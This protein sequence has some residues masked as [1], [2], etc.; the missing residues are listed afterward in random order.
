MN[1]WLKFKRLT[2]PGAKTLVTVT[3]IHN[4]GS[5]TVTLRDGSEVLVQG[6]SVEAGS[7]AFIQDGRIAGKAPDLPVQTIFV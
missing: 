3:T 1:P 4:N 6:D 2:A 5:S 7:K